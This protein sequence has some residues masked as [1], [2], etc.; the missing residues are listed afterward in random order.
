MN[1]VRSQYWA[2]NCTFSSVKINGAR[3]T[4]IPQYTGISVISLILKIL[5]LS[6]PKIPSVENCAARGQ[7]E[8]RIQTAASTAAQ[9]P[10]QV[11]VDPSGRYRSYITHLHPDTT[12]LTISKLPNSQVGNIK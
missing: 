11:E 8:V 6:P 5:L 3:V 12:L 1:R 10:V 9:Q 2:E 4:P 7:K